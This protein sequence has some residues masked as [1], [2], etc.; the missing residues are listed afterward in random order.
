M[1]FDDFNTAQPDPAIEA[2]I[3]GLLEELTLEEKVYMMSGH[4]FH[5]YFTQVDNRQFGQRAYAAGSGCE[6]L[7]IEPLYF[8]DGPRGKRHKEATTCFPVP[9]AR[10]ATF[11]VDLEERIGKA[12]GV[13]AR[14]LGVTLSGTI[15]INLLRHPGWGRAQETYGEDPFQ[16]GEF[17]AA[18][19]LIHI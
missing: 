15:C 4:G 5:Y 3:D 13:E 10:A 11:D 14:A 19:S 7:G 18:L 6:R 17:G 8:S 9:M 2:E 12:I 1:P 16:L